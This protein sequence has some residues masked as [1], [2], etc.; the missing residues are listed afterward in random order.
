MV[1][2]YYSLL[3][4]EIIYQKSEIGTGP[5]PSLPAASLTNTPDAEVLLQE[6][7]LKINPKIS[8]LDKIENEVKQVS[9]KLRKKDTTPI[10]TVPF[11]SQF[12]DISAPA[13]KKVG[14]GVASLAML[15]EYYNP[16]TV[17]VDQLL[18]EGIEADAY[19]DSAGWTY[20]GLISISKKYGL[21]GKTYDYGHLSL[22]QAYQK[23]VTELEDGPVMASVHYT[24][25]KSNPIPH[26]V[27]INGI[28]GEKVYYNDPAEKAGGGTV[29]VAQFQSA[30]KKRYLEFRLL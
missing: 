29:S 10:P 25:Q 15:I 23:L 12:D 14:C 21:D 26:L 18:E 30:W 6:P 8:E 5:L 7:G 4:G 1:T 11:F 3:D 2:S 27:I 17:T 20:A 24:F 22:E 9:T 28:E 19:L 16:G 13:W